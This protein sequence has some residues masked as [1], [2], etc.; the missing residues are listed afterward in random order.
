MDGQLDNHYINWYE[1]KNKE[2][3]FVSVW[4]AT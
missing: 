4:T 3:R 2:T 1:S